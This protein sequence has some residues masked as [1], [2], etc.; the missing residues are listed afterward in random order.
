MAPQLRRQAKWWSKTSNS[1]I[2]SFPSF[3]VFFR[4]AK[5]HKDTRN[6][7]IFANS[8]LV[9]SRIYIAGQC[10]ILGATSNVSV[11]SGIYTRRNNKR[12]EE[13]RLMMSLGRPTSLVIVEVLKHTRQPES[14]CGDITIIIR[15]ESA[16]Q[17]IL[18][19][20][21]N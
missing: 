4:S 2:F 3:P 21:F 12:R 7:Q 10:L 1:S 13:L 9:Y 18:C 20:V 11:P 19:L 15:D 14:C 5:I 6:T 16:S 8:I 17:L